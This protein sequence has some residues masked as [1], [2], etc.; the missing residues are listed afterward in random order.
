LTIV[1]GSRRFHT[2]WSVW[3]RAPG[4]ASKAR[5]L[6]SPELA[7]KFEAIASKYELAME[8]Y[9]WAMKRTRYGLAP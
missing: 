8:A 2:S 4:C 1:A 9:R 3:C 5:E 7:A 6:N